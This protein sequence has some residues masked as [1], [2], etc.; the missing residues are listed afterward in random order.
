[1]ARHSASRWLKPLS[2]TAAEVASS[3]I[4][5]SKINASAVTEGKIGALAVTVGKIG[6][7]AVTESKIGALAVTSGKI[8]ANAVVTAK[9]ADNNVT[10]AKLDGTLTYLVGGLDSKDSSTDLPVGANSKNTL[11]GKTNGTV[12]I[13]G[14]FKVNGTRTVT[15]STEVAVGDSEVIYNAFIKESG[16]NSD[17]G[18]HVKRVIEV[19][20]ID[21]SGLVNSTGTI[22]L[23]SDPSSVLSVGDIFYVTGTGENA[24]D[25]LYK[26][27]SFGATSIVIVSSP[28]ELGVRGSLIEE[29]SPP[30][31][32][33]VNKAD[34]ALIRWNEGTD[35]FQMGTLLGGLADIVDISSAQTLT[36]KTLTTPTIGSFAN[37]AHDHNDAAGGGNIPESAITDGSLLARLAA[38]E[39]VSGNWTFATAKTLTITDNVGLVV[40][41]AAL[42]AAAF[43]AKVGVDPASIANSA[44]T[45]LQ[46][47]LADLDSAITTGSGA[48]GLSTFAGNGTTTTFASGVTGLAQGDV[49]VY[50][51]GIYIPFQD[52]TVFDGTPGKEG[53]TISGDNIVMTVAHLA[54]EGLQIVKHNA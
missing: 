43:A 20:D 21:I 25:G 48:N 9:I 38:N 11:L 47:M 52:G 19:T 24:N 39:T 12:I 32:A 33:G 14:D 34:P 41:T 17:G 23:V 13:Q 40:G 16:A 42:N 3:A 46:A 36:N 15:T 18:F 31:G 4:E 22:N 37:S 44:S 1:M 54:G 10:P 5:E 26:V 49:S 2:I 8:G 45:N 30:S 29:S 28:T 27:A 51:D 6:A 50:V 53:W 35:K 7:L